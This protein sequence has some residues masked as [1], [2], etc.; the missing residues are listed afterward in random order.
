[1]TPS[2][3]LTS[4]E[5]E[6]ASVLNLFYIEKA[7]KL[8]EK[9]EVHCHPQNSPSS[10][11]SAPN[12]QNK[13]FEFKFANETRIKKTNCRLKPTRARGVDEIPATVLKL[14]VSILAAPITRL[15][16]VSLVSGV[17]PRAF[18]TALIVPVYKGKGKAKRDPASYCP[19]ALRPAMAKNT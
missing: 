11:R 4:T 2:G 17:V 13:F 6:S 19:I 12:S 16:N 3:T 8:C 5:A 14:G 1:V 10:P 15:V 9:L 18:K 7:M